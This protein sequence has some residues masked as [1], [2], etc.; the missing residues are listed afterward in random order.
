MHGC[1]CPQCAAC[2]YNGLSEAG[3][4]WPRP[5]QP[6][7][8]G[9][10]DPLEYAGPYT[11][12]P[13]MLPEPYTSPLTSPF[14]SPFPSPFSTPEPAHVMPSAEQHF[15]SDA[16]PE[17]R[18]AGQLISHVDMQATLA[19]LIDQYVTPRAAQRVLTT[20]QAVHPR[21][22]CR[23]TRRR[24]RSARKAYKELKGWWRWI[25]PSLYVFS[26]GRRGGDTPW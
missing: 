17:C 15:E 19:L 7:Q 4:H 5:Y 1:R 16:A 14:A 3:R 23:G 20:K 13:S 26:L 10:L 21:E 24:A 11:L 9:Y 6:T 12:R 8:T 22:A 18:H 2:R 25:V